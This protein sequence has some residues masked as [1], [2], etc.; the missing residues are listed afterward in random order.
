MKKILVLGCLISAVAMAA[1][2]QT[3]VNNELLNLDKEF[4]MLEQREAQKVE[5]Q[6]KAAELAA[7][8]LQNLEKLKADAVEKVAKLKAMEPSSVYIHDTKRIEKEYLRFIKL[9]DKAISKESQHVAEFEEIEI[10]T[11]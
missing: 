1:P 11:K 2:I 10:L 9:V 6:R 5:E 3:Q 7:Q 8:N 4:E